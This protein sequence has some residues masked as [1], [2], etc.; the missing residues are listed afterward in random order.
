[1]PQENSKVLSIVIPVFNEITFLKKLFEQIKLYFNKEN[2]EIIL[3]DDGST[4]GSSKLLNELKK[5]KIINF[6]LN[7]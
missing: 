4:D 1:M 3:V 2:I 7:S 5:K 6:N